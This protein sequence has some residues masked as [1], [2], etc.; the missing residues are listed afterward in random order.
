MNMRKIGFWRQYQWLTVLFLQA[1]FLLSVNGVR[2]EAPATVEERGIII[3]NTGGVIEKGRM[4]RMIAHLLPHRPIGTN[5][6]VLKSS[7]S[8]VIRVIDEAKVIEAVGEGQATVTASTLDGR[9]HSTVHYTVVPAR[10]DAHQE[11]KTYLIEPAK[12][13]IRYDDASEEAAKANSA[14]LHQA[15]LYT[16]ENGYTRLL[17]EEKKMFYVEPKDSIHMVSNVQLDLNGSEIRLRPNNY[18][19]YNAFLFAEH[20]TRRRVLENA[21][22]VNGTLTGERDHKAEHYPNWAKDAKTEGACTINF[23]EGRNNG[24]RDLTVR[25]SIGFN[26][27]SRT[28]RQAYGTKRFANYTIRHTNMEFGGY[29]EKG[30][31]VGDDGLM[32]TRQPIDISTLSNSHYTIGYPLGYVGYPFVHSRIF[33]AYFYDK[34]MNLLSASRGRI[35]FR[36]YELPAGAAFMHVVFHRFQHEGTYRAG[37]PTQGSADFQAAVAFVETSMPPINNYIIHCVIE[38]NYSTG[39]AACGGQ[40]WL[41]KDNTFRRNGGRMPGCDIDWEDGWEYMQNDVVTNNTFESRMNVITCAGVGLVFDH[42]TFRGSSIF[43][44]RTQHYSLINN[45]FAPADTEKPHQVKLTLESQ[46]DV[47][48]VGN[49]FVNAAVTYKRQ[50]AKPPFIGTYNATFI[51]DTFE[52]SSLR[53]APSTRVIDC[54]FNESSESYFD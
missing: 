26:I 27:A 16:A 17:L 25:K 43:Y 2:A 44:G 19:R 22:I 5:P 47:Y 41:I 9:F 1:A 28:G 39:M 50:H 20:P 4:E 53:M 36:L 46:T 6:F 37:L 48:L 30:K 34:E 29:D 40:G 38:D 31:A 45:V 42:N 14:G 33:D 24:I 49:R 12:F 7:D 52:K 51:R 23:A 21:S 10:V 8:S 15:L 54:I 3:G 32:R 35:R 18:A 13:G 11:G